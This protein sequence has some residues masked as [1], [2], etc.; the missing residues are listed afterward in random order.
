MFKLLKNFRWQD[1]LG[2]GVTIGLVVLSVY[3]EL[4]IPDYMGTMSKTLLSNDADISSI[5]VDGGYMILC[6]VATC[7]D[8]AIVYFISARISASFSMRLR[9]KLYAKV[10]RMSEQDIESFSTASL[11][12]PTTNDITQITQLLTMAM[13]LVF[14]A[15][16]M[17]IWSVV[18][19]LDKGNDAWTIAVGVAVAFLVVTIAILGGLAIPKFKKIQGQID[20]LNAMSRENIQGLRVIKAFNAEDYQGSKFDKANEDLTKT[21]NFAGIV[22]GLLS[23]VMTA[24]MSGLP[25]AIYW[26]GAYS[27]HAANNPADKLTT[28][29]NMMVF[30]SYATLVIMGFLMI[31]IVIMMSPRSLVAAKRVQEVLEK[32]DSIAEGSFDGKT[33]SVGELRFEHVYFGYDN[34]DKTAH[35]DVL[36]DIS[37]SVKK[38]ETLAIIGPT[39][40]G[41]STIIQLAMRFFDPN[42]GQIIL[43][44]HPIKEYTF[45]SLYNKIA[46]V[47]QKAVLFNDT[48]KDNIL[49]G[50]SDGYNEESLQKAVRISHSEEFIAK[51]AEGIESHIEQGGKNVSGGQKQRLSIARA[52][53]RNPEII[54]LD[55]SLSALDFKT[56]YEVRKA[57]HQEYPEM[58]KIVVAQRIGSVKEADTIIVLENGKIVGL[59]KHEELLSSCPLY[60]EIA[61][62]QLSEEELSHE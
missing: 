26:I 17:A 56:D 6:A 49:Y 33:E 35:E 7:I 44:G 57:L 12:T 59:G 28:F 24:V 23:P 19:I 39:G 5:L 50:D 46:L 54:I 8:M 11:I 36:S 25:V 9:E 58:T 18:K 14:K 3:L 13:S 48:I 2:V 42:K 22:M 52:L 53:A 37:F 60:K 32:E 4:L 45:L 41:K 16:I 10:Q 30:S 55:D 31:V 34:A 20:T 21:N 62:S 38:G 27:I 61:E 40:S 1:W 29:S 47:P 43:D 15:P 51:K